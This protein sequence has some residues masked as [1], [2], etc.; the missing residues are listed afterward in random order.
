MNCRSNI[1]NARKLGLEQDLP[2]SSKEYALAS[3]AFYIGTVLFSTIGGLMLKVVK[4]ATWLACCLVGWGTMGALQAVS[5]NAS[6]IT[7][8]RFFL[9][10]FEA[11]FAPGCALYLSFWYLKSELSLRIAAYAG[12][13]SMSGVISGLVAYGFGLLENKMALTAWQALFVV[14]GLPTV[15]CGFLIWFILP[16]RPETEK[17]AWFSD[18]EHAIA[19]ARRSRGTTQD[20]SGVDLQHVKASVVFLRF[21]FAPR[22][23]LTIQ[24]SATGHSLIRS[25]TFSPLSIRDYLY[26]SP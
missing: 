9:G 4:P 19:L 16:N 24:M 3:A 18:Q 2:L 1:G 17:S 15:A 21:E 23:L 26:L 5:Q 25:S 20:D 22:A 13:S 7:A 11:S 8:I 12:M 10:V 14:E 6:G